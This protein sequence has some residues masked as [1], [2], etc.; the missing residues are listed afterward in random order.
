[1]MDKLIYGRKFKYGICSLE[2]DKR[3]NPINKMIATSLD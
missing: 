3:T 2:F 1:M